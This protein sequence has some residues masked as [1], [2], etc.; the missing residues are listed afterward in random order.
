MEN[1]KDPHIVS[2][3]YQE[4]H[5][6]SHALWTSTEV[7]L[8][9]MCI[10]LHHGSYIWNRSSE[11]D[12]L[13]TDRAARGKEVLAHH[14]VSFQALEMTQWGSLDCTTG[15]S[16]QS[17]SHCCRRHNFS[18]LQCFPAGG[19]DPRI[20]AMGDGGASGG[21]LRSLRMCLLKQ[22]VYFTR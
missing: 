6:Y 22:W 7:T 14:E 1:S 8:H 12:S 20:L 15:F 5:T 16:T 17:K 19:C 21:V 3:Q 13:L 2:Y 18:I 10:V 9:W 11:V 4:S